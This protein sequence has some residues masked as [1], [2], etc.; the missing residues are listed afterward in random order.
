[1]RFRYLPILL[2]SPK[3]KLI[4]TQ[5]DFDSFYFYYIYLKKKL[6]VVFSKLFINGMNNS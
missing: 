1:M 6:D 4:R 2:P 5:V 3:K